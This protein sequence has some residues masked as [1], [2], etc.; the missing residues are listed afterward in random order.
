M[1][2]AVSDPYLL[3]SDLPACPGGRQEANKRAEATDDTAAMRATIR[4]AF[5]NLRPPPEPRGA[6]DRSA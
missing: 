3:L 1:L 6:R 4:R 2:S 5:P